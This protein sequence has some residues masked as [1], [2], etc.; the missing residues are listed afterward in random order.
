MGSSQKK[1]K[2]LGIGTIVNFTFPELME[3]T[4][5]EEYEVHG[6]NGDAKV[7]IVNLQEVIQNQEYQFDFI[8]KKEKRELVA[9]LID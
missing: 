3:S 1:S 7:M 8:V 9:K 4:I 6:T 2:Q 5:V